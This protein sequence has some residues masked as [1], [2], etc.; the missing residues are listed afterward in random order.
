MIATFIFTFSAFGI[1]SRK[2]AFGMHGFDA[3]VEDTPCGGFLVAVCHTLYI[4][5]FSL[6]YYSSV[7]IGVGQRG[8]SGG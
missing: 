4:V 1:T 8:S 5:H 7:R 3:V 2:A 6:G